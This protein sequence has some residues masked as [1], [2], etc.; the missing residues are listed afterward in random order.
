LTRLGT[1]PKE[2]LPRRYDADMMAALKQGQVRRLFTGGNAVVWP[3]RYR[4][5]G[6]YYE[7]EKDVY[8][9]KPKGKSLMLTLEQMFR[10]EV[11]P[12]VGDKKEW[13]EIETWPKFV[14]DFEGDF[15]V[16]CY[17]AML[18]MFRNHLGR[19]WEAVGVVGMRYKEEC[20]RV[21]QILLVITPNTMVYFARSSK[22]FQYL[23]PKVGYS[24]NLCDA[25]YPYH[26]YCEPREQADVVYA[27]M[28][29]LE[30]EGKTTE[31]K[32]EA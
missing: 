5:V 21:K 27:R 8:K 19:V 7:V 3:E 2:A 26:F 18:L 6:Y 29:W 22:A 20:R 11:L 16:E 13:V 30:V 12:P 14:Q 31:A 23:G 28:D 25:E 32:E 4:Q 1:K 24:A 9:L 15:T 17:V 10:D